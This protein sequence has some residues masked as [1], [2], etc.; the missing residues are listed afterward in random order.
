VRTYLRWT[1]QHKRIVAAY[2]LLILGGILTYVSSSE[3]IDIPDSLWPVVLLSGLALTFVSFVGLCLFVRCPRCRVRLFW[4][5]AS[6]DAHPHG[7][8]GLLLATKCPFC[9]FPEEPSGAV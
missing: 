5:A 1:G 6:E 7:L 9:S 2:G 8:N 3:W 4:H